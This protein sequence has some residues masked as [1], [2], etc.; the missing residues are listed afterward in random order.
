[1]LEAMPSGFRNSREGTASATVAATGRN[2]GG[3]RAATQRQRRSFHPAGC[4]APSLAPGSPLRRGTG[5]RPEAS[6]STTVHT[7]A[8]RARALRAGFMSS[9]PHPRALALALA[10]PRPAP[11]AAEPTHP[12][13][14]GKAR[15]S[16]HAHSSFPAAASLRLRETT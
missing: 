2:R 12:T 4:P 6:H 15:L 14:T 11:P 9:F 3:G 1:M 5:S 7:P 10:L 13:R 8:T 16:P